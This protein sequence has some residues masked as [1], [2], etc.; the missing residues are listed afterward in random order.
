MDR[1]PRVGCAWE[2]AHPLME[3]HGHRQQ[4]HQLLPRCSEEVDRLYEGLPQVWRGEGAFQ[5]RQCELSYACASKGLRKGL[6]NFGWRGELQDLKGIFG[7]D[8]S[9]LA[10]HLQGAL[11]PAEFID[12]ALGDRVAACPHAA[13]RDSM[14][15]G[16]RLVTA[17]GGLVH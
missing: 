8:L 13:L 17:L 10:R 3:I 5:L 2:G 11:E 12:E 6:K 7:R 4:C 16:A 15:V 9:E 14:D 1:L